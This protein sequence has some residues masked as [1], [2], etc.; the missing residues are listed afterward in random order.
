M[1]SPPRCAA[2][3]GLSLNY[4]LRGPRGMNSCVKPNQPKHDGKRGT[5]DAD[6]PTSRREHA[7]LIHSY[8]AWKK[9]HELKQARRRT[10]GRLS[11]FQP[12]RSATG[13]T[14]QDRA[15]RQRAV[16]LASTQRPQLGID[17]E[18][19]TPPTPRPETS[20]AANPGRCL[21]RGHGK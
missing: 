11:A 10:F 1:I 7:P 17:D 15:D 9:Q 20:G 8:K 4:F 3:R 5:Q 2:S 6:L 16:V 13:T 18:V 14:P 12:S 21:R 19:A